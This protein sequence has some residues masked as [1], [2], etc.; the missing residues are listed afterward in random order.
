MPL[1]TFS[2]EPLP[3][4]SSS[5]S[6]A[7]SCTAAAACPAPLSRGGSSDGGTPV[8][9]CTCC[10]PMR[11]RPPD[12]TMAGQ[13]AKYVPWTTT[14]GTLPAARVMGVWRPSEASSMLW[15]WLA[16]MSQCFGSSSSGCCSPSTA[17]LS[18]KRCLALSAT[19][20]RISARVGLR[21][22]KRGH[23]I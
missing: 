14:S 4:P 8:P 21:E 23:C 3:L 15:P 10:L 7:T 9:K 6:S 20:C 2:P 22:R 11:F 18:V 12:S 19:V 13:K 16:R 1:M 5:C 17:G